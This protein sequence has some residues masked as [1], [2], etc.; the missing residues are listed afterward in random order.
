MPNPHH[1][2]MGRFGTGGGG[3]SGKVSGPAH[4]V[5]R[6]GTSTSG[7]KYADHVKTVQTAG[8][9]RI[10][11]ADAAAE[12]YGTGST[13]HKKALAM[14]AKDKKKAETK[15]M[16]KRLVTMTKAAEIAA[17]LDDDDFTMAVAD[18]RKLGLSSVEIITNDVGDD[19][20]IYLGRPEGLM[21]AWKP[22]DWTREQVAIPGGETEDDIHMTVLY[23]GDVSAFST[24]EQ[25][26]IIGVTSQV[27]TQFAEIPAKIN[28]FGRFLTPDSEDRNPLWLSV[29]AL[30]LQELHDTLATALEEAGIVWEEKFDSYVP[31]VTVAYV[32]AEQETPA[33]WVNPM[34]VCIDNLTV[35]IG[36]L[37]YEI[38]LADRDDDDD[39]SSPLPGSSEPR[40][41]QLYYPI[42]KATGGA[43]LTFTDDIRYSYGPWY[44]P[45]SVDAHGE[46]ADRDTVQ[47]SLWDYVDSGDR[48]IRLQHDTD[49]VAGRWVELATVP[50]PLTVP[51]ET[52]PGILRK[53]TYPAGTPFMGVIWEEWSWPLVKNG[54][55]R[56]FSVG[57]TAQ[58]I[59][60]EFEPEALTKA[61]AK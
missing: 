39:F 29:E 2:S 49:V 10:S 42:V 22:R 8:G 28:G 55:L 43:E 46:W 37:E 34:D 45:N 32:P 35:Y 60:A 61:R 51:V 33:V 7:K 14:E 53:H 58:R 31:H 56:G 19:T 25:R 13:Q 5:A 40:P 27:A 3:G 17:Q 4:S 47:K 12:M 16:K 20:D 54:D 1:D 26:T 18:A 52:E 59:E 38:E 23:L 21:I 6:G 48:D 9:R 41:P 24:E 44:V 36:G 15:T 57:G 11:L 50:F 30:G